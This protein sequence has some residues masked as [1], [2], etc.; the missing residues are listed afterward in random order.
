MRETFF[1]DP[2]ILAAVIAVLAIVNYGLGLLT[3][4]RRALQ[5]YVTYEPLPGRIRSPKARFALPF[6]TAVPAM[7]FAF[8]PGVPQAI[9]AGGYII[10]QAFGI[11]LTIGTAL[12]INALRATR[13][14]EGKLRFSA[15]FQYRQQS[16]YL[17]GFALFAALIA[18]LTQSLEFLGAFIW[19]SATSLGY[20]RR[21]RQASRL[22]Q[23]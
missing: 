13:S 3:I 7:I 22:G 14:A 17:A 10:M 19:L 2:L 21:A 23:V 6:V 4:R 9:F 8:A 12:S 11:A 15:G 5:A 1:T 16:S 20:F 18:A